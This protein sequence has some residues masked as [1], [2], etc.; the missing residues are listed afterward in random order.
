M[1]APIAPGTRLTPDE[2]ADYLGLSP[3]TLANWR[4]AGTGPT[5]LRVGGRIQY[6]VQDLDEFLSTCTA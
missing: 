5:H 4:S 1:I 6:R 2:A 3:K